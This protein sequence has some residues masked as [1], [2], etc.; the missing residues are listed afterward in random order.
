[1]AIDPSGPADEVLSEAAWT[2]GLAIAAYLC[3]YATEG[4]EPHRL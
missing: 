3:G 2:A 4:Y 1:M